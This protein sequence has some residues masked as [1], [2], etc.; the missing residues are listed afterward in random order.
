MRI[1]ERIGRPMAAVLLIWIPACATAGGWKEVAVAPLPT[2]Q[3]RYA[4]DVRVATT[5][6]MVYDLRGLWVGP[7]SLGG[8]LVEPA[9]K[10]QSF[11]LGDVT[12]LEVRTASRSSRTREIEGDGEKVVL[13]AIFA[14]IVVA[15]AAGIAVL[16]DGW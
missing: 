13:L 9:G 10:E 5:G 2:R 4:G 11:A 14:G 7:D 8:W 1:P 16:A 3:T 6:G 12:R 15:S